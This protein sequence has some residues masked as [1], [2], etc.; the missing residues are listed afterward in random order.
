MPP[1]RVRV[2]SREAATDGIE[3]EVKSRD[4]A[5]ESE[6]A[7]K[8]RDAASDSF[9]RLEAVTQVELEFGRRAVDSHQPDE[10]MNTHLHQRQVQELTYLVLDFADAFFQLPMAKSEQ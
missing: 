6:S 3:S 8:L 5:N 9:E 4:A 10:C 7:V 1:M 2:Q